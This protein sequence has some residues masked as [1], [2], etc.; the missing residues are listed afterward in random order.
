ML[1]AAMRQRAFRWVEE[2]AGDDSSFLTKGKGQ[3]NEPNYG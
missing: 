3:E 2:S 1:A